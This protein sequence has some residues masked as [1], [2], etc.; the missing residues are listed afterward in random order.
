[1]VELRFWIHRNPE[2][3]EEAIVRGG[4]HLTSAPPGSF[5]RG[6]TIWSLAKLERACMDLFGV[7]TNLQGAHSSIPKVI[8]LPPF[9]SPAMSGSRSNNYEFLERT[10]EG[11]YRRIRDIEAIDSMYLFTDKADIEKATK[12]C[13]FLLVSLQQSPDHP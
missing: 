11:Q 9:S 1:M 4:A 2:Y 8:Y 3:L 7:T 10:M 13:G 5:G 12:H 6:V